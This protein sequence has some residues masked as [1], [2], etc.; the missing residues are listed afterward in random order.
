MDIEQL[1]EHYNL[2]GEL[3]REYFREEQALESE[4][5]EAIRQREEYYVTTDM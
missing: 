4:E 3:W 1:I 5:A 2:D